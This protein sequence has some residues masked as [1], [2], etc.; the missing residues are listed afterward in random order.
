MRQSI[1]ILSVL[2]VASACAPITEHAFVKQPIGRPL[3]AGVGD[4]ILT[5]KTEK[6]LPNVLGRADLFGRTTPTGLVSVQFL[7]VEGSVATF[8]RHGVDIETGATTM[9]STPLIIPNTSQTT[10]SGFA[11]GR[12]VMG[13]ATTYA[14]PTVIPAHPPEVERLPQ[15]DVV[16]RVDLNKENGFVVAGKRIRI[17]SATPGSL[18]YRID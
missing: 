8:V 6:S 15:S 10:F 3:E 12:P 1:V 5:I 4:T 16:I 13:T 14:T 2:A 7:G 17:L 11:G 9:N 18:S